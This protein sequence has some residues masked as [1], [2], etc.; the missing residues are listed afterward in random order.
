MLNEEQKKHFLD[1]HWEKIKST[2]FHLWQKHKVEKQNFDY[3]IYVL[4]KKEFKDLPLAV[5]H[6]FNDHIQEGQYSKGGEVEEGATIR[7][8]E[9][10][11]MASFSNLYGKD[12]VIKDIKNVYFASGPQKYFIVE[13]EGEELS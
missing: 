8:E 6:E 5:E 12:L 2:H 13:V 10:P 1:D 9:T 11:Y 3:S 7:I 4:S